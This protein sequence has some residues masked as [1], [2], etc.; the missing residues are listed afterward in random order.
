VAP[1]ALILHVSGA[2][3]DWWRHTMQALLPELACRSWDAPGDPNEIDYA[4]VWKPP[5]GGLARFPRLKAVFSIGAGVDHILCDPYLPEVPVI[6]LA[7]APLAQRMREYVALH[8]LRCHRRQRE[9]D[10]AQQISEWRQLITP[11]AGE[12]AVGVMGLGELGRAA[13][14]TLAALGFRVLGWTRTPH[15]IEDV[16]C[17]HGIGQQPDFLACS[18]ILVCLLPLTRQTENILGRATFEQLPRGSHIINAGRGEHLD[19]ADLLDA[20]DSGQLAGA[21]LDVFRTEPLPPGHPF[22]AHPQITVTP[23]LASLVDPETGSRL[24]A[25][26]IRRFIA[27]D[28]L[29]ELRVDRERGY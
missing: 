7:G 21:V 2:R 11:P 6:R 15:R 18:R 19:E 1:V 8:V 9:L 26:N 24:L 22:W 23:H 10:T 29:T 28:P 4:V 13:A 12:C 27:G 3:A 25:A 5:P 17:F 20:L 14:G 16:E